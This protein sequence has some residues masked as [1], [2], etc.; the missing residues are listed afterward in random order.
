MSGTLLANVTDITPGETLTEQVSFSEYTPGTDTIQYT[1][2]QHEHTYTAAGVAADDNSYWTVTV[3][4]GITAL[5]SAGA[6][7]FQGLVT[8]AGVVYLADEGSLNVRPNLGQ[9][10]FEQRVLSA[11][12]AL[13]ENRATDDQVTLALDGVS[14]G[15]MTPDQLL[16]WEQT[17]ARRV[18]LQEAD[19]QIRM[20]GA[21]PYRVNVRFRKPV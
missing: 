15:R 7:H 5:W 3:P 9:V 12:R 19:A 11:I 8:S 1:F 6:V 18:A 20:G 21:N 2:R 16:K 13:L 4:A 10:T 14:L 17:F